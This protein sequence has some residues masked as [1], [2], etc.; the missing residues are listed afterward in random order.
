ML[1]QKSDGIDEWINHTLK[2]NSKTLCWKGFQTERGHLCSEPL[3][4][5]F[6]K[7][8]KNDISINSHPLSPAA[9]T[10]SS[11]ESQQ[12]LW[13]AFKPDFSEKW[14]TSRLQSQAQSHNSNRGLYGATVR[15]AYRGTKTHT[16]RILSER[17]CSC[18]S[19]NSN[20]PFLNF[21]FASTQPSPTPCH[22]PNIVILVCIASIQPTHL[23][24]RKSKPNN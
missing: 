3:I 22:G 4:K 15:K 7:P 10:S 9:G 6:L 2:T 11:A 24:K 1:T 5:D 8:P 12:L 17:T 18:S 19:R 13:I 21:S 20:G 23:Y 14:Q 16:R